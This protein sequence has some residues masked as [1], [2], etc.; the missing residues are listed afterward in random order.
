[1][2][3]TCT[4]FA[5]QHSNLQGFSR[6]DAELSTDESDGGNQAYVPQQK[7]QDDSSNGLSATDGE[8][9]GEDAY[10][11]KLRLRREARRAQ[12]QREGIEAEN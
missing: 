10:Q 1:V 2:A 3:K 8:K 5:L 6:V 11:R 4:S 12:S 7:S 9:T